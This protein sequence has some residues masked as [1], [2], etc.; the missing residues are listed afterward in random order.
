MEE[1][2]LSGARAR[3]V[4]SAVF[5]RVAPPCAAAVVPRAAN[6]LSLCNDDSWCYAVPCPTPSTPPENIPGSR[7]STTPARGC[8]SSRCA[9]R[10]AS[11]LLGRV[12]DGDIRP[13]P[14][15]AMVLEVWNALPTHYPGVEID[16]FVVMP[17]HIHGIL[18]L[19]SPD[20][21]PDSQG[22]AAPTLSLLEVV[23]RFKSLTTRRYIAGVTGQRWPRFPSQLWQKS[24]FE[25]VIRGDQELYNAR[26]YVRE[27]PQQWALDQENPDR[28]RRWDGACW[29]FPTRGRRGTSRRQQTHWRVERGRRHTGVPPYR[30]SYVICHEAV[31]GYG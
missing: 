27:N 5:G 20:E 14:A 30:S 10:I 8:I 3:Q 31:W 26:R 12:I 25:R 19:L 22:L 24:F 7:P 1:I 13:S 6:F 29:G 15:G 2:P 28:L 16:E 11:P 17:N 21:S 18:V 9:S 4:K 23:Q